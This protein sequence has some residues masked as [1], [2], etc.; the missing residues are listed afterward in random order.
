[1][2]KNIERWLRPDGLALIAGWRRW[3]ADLKEVASKMGVT[4]ATLKRWA[5]TNEEIAKAM[6]IDK[7]AADFL[8][9]Q[10]IFNKALAGDTKAVEFW[11]KYRGAYSTTP[12]TGSDDSIDY[13]GLASLINEH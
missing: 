2:E 5:A 11:L 8:V 9:E 1:M 6:E 10:A 7:Q 4:Q 3:G 12:T 13:A